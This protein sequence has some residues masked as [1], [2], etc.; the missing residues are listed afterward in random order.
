MAGEI[1]NAADVLAHRTEI[2]A[3]RVHVIDAT[4]LAPIE[5]DL[6]VEHFE[7]VQEN[8]AHHEHPL[9]AEGE[10]RQLAT[11][12]GRAGERLLAEHV[13]AGLQRAFTRP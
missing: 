4:Q 6:Q 13:L 12:R 3:H 8:V 7:V 10:V 9:A 2:G 1:V 11:F 5:I